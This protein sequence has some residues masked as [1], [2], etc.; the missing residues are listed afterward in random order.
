MV[1]KSIHQVS[2]TREARLRDRVTGAATGC[3]ASGGS[4]TS[5]KP[6][7]SFSPSGVEV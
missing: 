4:A 3:I 2:S 1:L 7:I 5:Y 6:V